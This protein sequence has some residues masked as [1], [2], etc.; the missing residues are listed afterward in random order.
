M[1]RSVS[2]SSFAELRVLPEEHP[3]LLIGPTMELKSN[4]EKMMEV[5][6]DTFRVPA[7]HISLQTILSLYSSGRTTGVVLNIGDGLTETLPLYEGYSIMNALR[8][9]HIAGKEMTNYMMKLLNENGLPLT[10]TGDMELARII[11]EKTCY[12]ARDYKAELEKPSS[13]VEANFTL[14]NKETFFVGAERF[15]APEL[16]FQPSLIGVSTP[17]ISKTLYD[18]IMN[19]DVD[20]R[21]DLFSN[22]VLSGSTTLIPGFADRLNDELLD[23]A[24]KKSAVRLVASPERHISAWI[25]GSILASLSTFQSMWISREEYDDVGTNIVNLKCVV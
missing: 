19:S 22:I 6:F 21:T 15:K 11:K 23:L 4:R 2:F 12:V 9:E 18:T 13:E 5:M 14:P 8:K 7:T 16:L 20:V 17:G 1:T 10:T 24:P 25:G 3:T